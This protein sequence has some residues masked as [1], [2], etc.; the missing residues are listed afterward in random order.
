[1][2]IKQRVLFFDIETSPNLG[3]IWEKY[4][5]DVIMFEKERDLMSFAYKWQGDSKVRVHSLGELTHKQLVSKLHELFDEA[6]VVCVEENTPVLKQDLTWVRA[7]QLISGDKIVAFEEGSTPNGTLRDR[8]GKWRGTENSVRRIKPATVI[9]NKI[10]KRECFE[11][12]LSNGDRITT[13]PE[14]YWLGKTKKDNFYKWLKTKD[15]KP[16]YRFTKFWNVWKTEDSYEAGWLSG[17]IAG[18]G[19]LGQSNRSFTV[20][21]YQRPGSTWN[22][23]LN[24]C[25]KLGI[26]YSK[27]RTQ[28]ATG[29]G[30]QDTLATGILGGKFIIAEA[31]GK[32]QIK[33]FIEKINWEK[34]G[35]LKGKNLETVEVISVN[36]VGKKKVAV[37]STDKKTFFAG[38]YAMH[39][40]AHNGDKFDIK[41]ANSFFIKYGLTPPS[42]YKSIDTLKIAK[43]IFRFNSNKLNDLGEYLGIG[44]KINTG[45]FQLWL[46]CLRGEKSA[47]AKM[48]R[49]NK[50]D[51]VL[52][53]KV[54]NKLVPWDNS[55][56]EMGFV[57]PICGST[58]LQKRG[59]N[60]NKIYK[61]QRY[62]CRDCGRWSQS[63]KRIKFNNEEYLK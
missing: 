20:S 14:H 12:V 62:Q 53:E 17:F 47:W 59:W 49:Y 31:I 21:F 54:Y 61:S 56:T 50:Q 28:R 4:E 10:E 22:Q 60:I 1:M 11:V 32:L 15:L 40:C 27:E 55:N 46:R 63:N 39:N 2:Y 33:R 3:Y 29:I 5:Q 23:A 34:F 19:S 18:E 58:N 37:M 24:Y 44:K 51:V 36:P 38:G 45:G 16:G 41:M 43:K 48:K 9:F 42:P 8:A 30:R 35:G 6:D 57:C 7:G 26:E 25:K 13:T 52:L